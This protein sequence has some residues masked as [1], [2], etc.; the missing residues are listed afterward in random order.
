MGSDFSTNTN[1]P[2]D[3]GP[4]IGDN[5]GQVLRSLHPNHPTRFPL[6]PQFKP[7]IDKRKMCMQFRHLLSDSFVE[8]NF[9]GYTNIDD[10]SPELLKIYCDLLKEVVAN[11]VEETVLSKDLKTNPK[12]RE[13]N[14]LL[15]SKSEYEFVTEMGVYSG[16]TRNNKPSG[17]GRMIY[18]T[19]EVYQGSWIDG[20]RHG[21]GIMTD[22]KGVV[23]KG[24]W[25][26]DI[27]NGPF[28]VKHPNGDVMYLNY[29]EGLKDGRFIKLSPDKKFAEYQYFTKDL[30]ES[31]VQKFERIKNNDAKEQEINENPG[32]LTKLN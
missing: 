2:D 26:Y 5:Q 29:S 14:K 4:H 10:M 9:Q 12:Y 1:V 30:S 24:T 27:M 28:V 15:K 20:K 18:K 6:N 23:W 21:E 17:K 7:V 19:K 25:R 8:K 16:D 32:A 13:I 22:S 31:E 11:Q 3:T